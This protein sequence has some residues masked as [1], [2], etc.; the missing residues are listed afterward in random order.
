MVY[1]R[2]RFNS[3]NSFVS[4]GSLSFKN[5]QYYSRF[6]HIIKKSNSHLQSIKISR[7]F[8]HRIQFDSISNIVKIIECAHILPSW[9]YSRIYYSSDLFSPLPINSHP[10]KILYKNFHY[11]T[12]MR[13]VIELKLPVGYRVHIRLVHMKRPLRTLNFQCS[14]TVAT[15][16][17][18][19]CSHIVLTLH[20]TS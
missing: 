14:H 7:Y 19:R 16:N 5:S 20:F 17:L 3:F 6:K 12:E 9:F 4:F 10:C 18:S 11:I 15:L 13:L 1:R 2:L 8:I